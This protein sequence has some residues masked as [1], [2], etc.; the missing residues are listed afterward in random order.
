MASFTALYIPADGA[1][2]LQEMTLSSEG[3][4]ER[5]ALRMH[6]EEVFGANVDM[7]AKQAQVAANLKEQGMEKGKISEILGTLGADG[8]GGGGVSRL[9]SA[10]EIVTACLPTERNAFQSVSFY[11]DANSAFKQGAVPNV[12]ATQVLQAAGHK[13]TVVM[14]DCYVGRALDDERIEWK[15]EN[16]GVVDFAVDAPWVIAASE[17]N[18]GK[19]MSSFTTSGA[20]QMMGGGGGGGGGGAGGG[21]SGGGGGGGVEVGEQESTSSGVKWSETSSTVDFSFPVQSLTAKQLRVVI[22]AKT[23][24]VSETT[25]PAVPL[26]SLSLAGT[27]SIDEST[28]TVA[29]GKIEFS[30]EK[31]TQK[32]W[33]KLEA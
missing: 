11:C 3:G 24:S 19:K 10:V 21:E 25:N 32:N 2:P 33:G 23:I 14:G 28:W 27:V 29:D 5:D 4:L 31:T 15:R 17:A 22:S 12:R 6:C 9:G 20:L 16:F 8:G 18:S 13:D 1:R 26:L 7:Q 30:L